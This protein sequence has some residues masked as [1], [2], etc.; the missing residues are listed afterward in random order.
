MVENRNGLFPL[1]TKVTSLHNLM[2]KKYNQSNSGSLLLMTL[3]LMIILS[4]LSATAL[5]MIYTH[6]LS[7]YQENRYQQ[8][9]YLT[10]AGARQALADVRVAIEDTYRDMLY[11][12]KYQPLARPTLSLQQDHQRLLRDRMYQEFRKTLIA[13]G[14]LE[15]R[16][17]ILVGFAEGEVYARTL[18]TSM[19]TSYTRLRIEITGAI[20]G[21]IRRIDI[22]LTLHH[23]SLLLDSYL[24]QYAAFVGDSGVSIQDGS[25]IM[26]GNLYSA[27]EIFLKRSELTISGSL[28]AKSGLCLSEQSTVV[29][30]GDTT[31]SNLQVSESGNTYTAHGDVYA[32]EDIGQSDPDNTVFVYGNLYIPNSEGFS[33]EFSLLM[34]ERLD[35]NYRGHIDKSISVPYIHATI[36]Y[37]G[38]QAY[39]NRPD[40]QPFLL[41]YSGTEEIVLSSGA[42]HGILFTEGTI[43]ILEGAVVDFDGF[44]IAEGGLILEGTL[45]IRR[46]S[47][48]AP[49]YLERSKPFRDFLKIQTQPLLTINSYCEVPVN[50]TY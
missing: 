10:E 4:M 26:E 17:L 18:F 25:L 23:N 8:V 2:M 13:R 49:S 6:Y 40:E 37:A 38:E 24:F 50:L 3:Y 33:E 15:K 32:S 20:G 35:F 36:H 31:M 7:L 21:T 1:T 34:S 48:L 11:N 29:V 19:S 47:G 22:L 43:R 39:V 46:N 44:L 5:P 14:Y 28:D 42:Y 41:I 12:Y 16:K 30:V 27:G 45:T 9:Y